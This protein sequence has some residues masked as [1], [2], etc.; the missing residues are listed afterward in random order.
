[1]KS[2]VDGPLGDYEALKNH[3]TPGYQP[4]TFVKV[5]EGGQPTKK[6][7]D[8]R[9]EVSKA[10]IPLQASAPQGSD[11]RDH[12]K[13]MCSDMVGGAYGPA[14][15]EADDLQHR[16]ADIVK[17][18][19]NERIIA[20]KKDV[21]DQLPTVGKTSVSPAGGLGNALK[22][23][24]KGIPVAQQIVDEKRKEFETS[25]KQREDLCGGPCAQK[26]AEL[27]K[28]QKNLDDATKERDDINNAYEKHFKPLKIKKCP[29]AE[30]KEHLDVL[31][32]LFESWGCE[33]CLLAGFTPA[34]KHGPEERGPWC[35]K[36]VAE[37]DTQFKTPLQKVEAK[38]KSCSEAREQAANAYREAQ[39]KCD[40][41]KEEEKKKK[42]QLD[43]ALK[44]QTTVNDLCELSKRVDVLTKEHTS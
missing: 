37:M 27:A 20:G 19:L 1:M 13:D 34:A 26:K 2:F 24:D 17:K 23:K 22:D 4:D 5:A 29:T 32:P 10:S 35:T 33:D 7:M 3:E 36:V 9:Q 15:K 25:S 43:D 41:A 30:V 11:T 8:L 39:R 42:K 16:A 6:V 38:I 14:P 21:D 44:L 40:D 12:T 18:A 31:G 28:A